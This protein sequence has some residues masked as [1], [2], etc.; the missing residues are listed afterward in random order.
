MAKSSKTLTPKQKA[1]IKAVKTKAPDGLPT[2][3]DL[4]EAVLESYDVK[5]TESKT[6]YQHASTMG[7]ELIKIPKVA[8]HLG[9]KDLEQ[10]FFNVVH[11]ALV[12]A[13][14]QHPADKE[15]KRTAINVL[16]RHFVPSKS[17]ETVTVNAMEQRSDEDLAFFTEH[18]YW[19]GELPTPGE[20]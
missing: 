18:G 14:I 4:A 17:E 12:G 5:D 2:T 6:A 9:L 19:P 15:L 3:R 13:D 7:N 10:D 16:S 20:A 11:N 1:F 8:K